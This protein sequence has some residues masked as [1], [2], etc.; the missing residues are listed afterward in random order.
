[1]GATADG[2]NNFWTA[3]TPNGTYWFNPPLATD[4]VQTNGGN[5]IAV[6]I[7]GGN[8]YFSTQKGVN[9]IYTFQGDGLPETGALTN[10]V[11]ATGSSS[12]PAGFDLSPD[13]TVAYVAD[14]RTSSAG[15]IQ[16]W[17]NGLGGWGLAYTL[18]TGASKA[19]AYGVIVDFSGANPVL[20]ATTV[21]SSSSNTN[22]LISVMDTGPD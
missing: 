13:L 20:Y 14:Q 15:G 10:L 19:G 2:T 3:G 22:R 11:I 5:T 17:T 6:R 12:Q 18:S 1:R 16:K 9:G 21:D 8:L 7:L 4:D